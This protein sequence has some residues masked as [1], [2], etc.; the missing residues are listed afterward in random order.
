MAIEEQGLGIKSKKT[1]YLSIQPNPGILSI[2]VTTYFLDRNK[3]EERI[4]VSQLLF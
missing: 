4:I 2:V 3:S 1:H